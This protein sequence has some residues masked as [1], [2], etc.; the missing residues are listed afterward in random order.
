MMV[1]EPEGKN[2][3]G[4]PTVG[5]PTHAAKS[6]VMDGAPTVVVGLAKEKHGWASPPL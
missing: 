1:L 3:V 6:R 2:T 5:E 4:A